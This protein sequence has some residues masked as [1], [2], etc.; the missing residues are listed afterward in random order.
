[1]P[2]V[3]VRLLGRRKM[4]E[5]RTLHGGTKMV[6]EEK[7]QF[8]PSAYAVILHAGKIILERMKSTGMYCLPGGGIELGEKMEDGLKREVREETGIDIE[9]RRFAYFKED[10]FY[11][12]PLGEAFHSFMFFFVCKALTTELIPDDKVE[13]FES[14]TPRWVDAA[15][16]G[17]KDFYND[18]EAILQ[19]IASGL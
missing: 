4:V 3:G 9:I 19:I 5:C 13:D 14:E 7:L 17:A 6:P 16:L 1:M 11:Y 12:D 2:A 8:R 18:G 15:G 10:F